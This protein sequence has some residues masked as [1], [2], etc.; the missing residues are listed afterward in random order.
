MKRFS[1]YYPGCDGTRLA[2]DVYLPETLPEGGVPAVFHVGNDPR[3]ARYEHMKRFIDLLLDRGY[4]VVLPEPRGYGVSY[5]CNEGFFNRLDGH[6]IAVLID[7]LAEEDWC[8]GSVGMFGGSNLGN[9]QE[10]TAS[11]RPKHLKSIIPC[12]CNTNGYYQ[13]YPNGASALPVGF[14]F[15]PPE[16]WKMPEPAFVDDDPEGT[17]AEEAI[18]QHVGNGAFL[19]QYMP[20]MHRDTVHP[21]LGYATNTDIPVWSYMDEVRYSDLKVYQNAAWYDPGCTGSLITYQ[22]WGGKVLLGPWRHVEI[23]Q[24]SGE[25]PEDDF[26]WMGEH[27]KFLDATL[28]GSDPTGSLIEPDIRYYTRNAAE[29]DRWRYAAGWPLDNQRTAEL[30]LLPDGVM[31]QAAV[32]EG[33]IEYRV[34]DDIPLF[35]FGRLNRKLYDGFTA[36]QDKCVC[37]TAQPVPGDMEI[38]GIPVVELWASSTYH[39]GNFIAILLDVAPD[40]ATQHITEGVIRASQAEIDRNLWWDALGL[41]YHPGLTGRDSRLDGG[42]LRLCFNMEG[43]SYV[44]PA[45]HRLRLCVCCGASNTFQQPEG[46]PEDVTVTF[47]FGG[48]MRPML[49]LPVAEPDVSC[50]RSGDTSV[51]AFKKGV[52]L[53]RGGVWETHPCTQV[54]PA[55]DGLHYVTDDFTLVKSVSGDTVTAVIDAPGHAFRAS[56]KL[57]ALWRY[58]DAYPVN[59]PYPPPRMSRPP[60]YR[61]EKLLRDLYVATVPVRKGLRDHPNIEPYATKDLRIDLAL[62]GKTDGKAPCIVTIHGFGGTYHDFEP[63]TPM[64]LERGYAV[65]SIEFRHYPPNIWPAPAVDAKGCI[66][67]LKAHAGEL[68]LDPDRFGLLGGS[69]GGHLSSM[70]AADNGDGAW[71]GDVGG[72]CGFDSGVRAAAVY[73]PWVDAFTFADQCAALY[74]GRA[75]KYLNADGPFAPLGC[76]VDFSGYGKGMGELKKHLYDPDPCYQALIQRARDCSP[77]TH[78]SGKSAPCALIHGIGE[79]GIE[80]P[81]DQSVE[82]FEALTRA[83]VPSQLYCNNL[84]FFGDEPEIRQAVVDFL[85]KRV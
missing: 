25:L 55:A 39:D 47:H 44:L 43:I 26:D 18:A 8:S 66:R 82:F 62:P 3:R 63:V 9:I 46:M 31:G 42:P 34:R 57:P 73:F 60:K 10:L 38:T 70:I 72:N 6:D 58:P 81:M 5:G 65:A 61:P 28:K 2:V 48:A 7:T 23:Y 40:G 27:L 52:W 84:N 69:A 45:G 4:A 37:F 56:G 17:Q 41:P 22:S 71:E 24:P 16:G 19:A 21:K 67:Y 53:C 79:C 49:R 36:Q 35:G 13:N 1:R 74:P 32:P 80:I 68:G 33:T 75:D 51:Y 64:L 83:G 77:I 29:G 76:M 59:H 50:F 12:D 15:V 11:W 78:V 14:S 54:Y 30:N 20:N 85:A